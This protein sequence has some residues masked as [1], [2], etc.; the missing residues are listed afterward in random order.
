MRLELL[1]EPSWR[2]RDVRHSTF[3]DIHQKTVAPV[4]AHGEVRGEVV[5]GGVEEVAEP[6]GREAGWGE[7]LAYHAEE[8]VGVRVCRAGGDEVARLVRPAA[9]AVFPASRERV[10]A[11][12][13]R[14]G[15]PVGAGGELDEGEGE[16][17]P[18]GEA[19]A[20]RLLNGVFGKGAGE[21][22]VQDVRGLE[23]FLARVGAEVVGGASEAEQ[24]GGKMLV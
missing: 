23:H 1:L 16:G 24:V 3:T 8:E 14:G 20:R 6:R 22:G 19:M 9:R 18:W 17:A 7:V 15:E 5:E 4:R 10:V 2:D 12:A 21:E 11:D 13:V